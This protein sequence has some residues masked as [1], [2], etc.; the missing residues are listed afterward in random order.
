MN[1]PFAYYLKFN[2]M[3]VYSYAVVVNRVLWSANNNM[4]TP[5]PH[6]LN[7]FGGG[8]NLHVVETVVD[9]FLYGRDIQIIRGGSRRDDDHDGGERSEW[10]ED[11]YGDHGGAGTDRR[12]QADN[13]YTTPHIVDVSIVHVFCRLL[14]DQGS[15]TL[16]VNTFT[17]RAY[18]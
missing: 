3:K 2:Q 12:L 16:I 14:A 9:H 1:N 10:Y 18:Q 8:V 11:T 4:F 17:L 13:L 7:N 6:L 15:H 5:C